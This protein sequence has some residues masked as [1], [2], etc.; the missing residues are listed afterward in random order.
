MVTRSPK[1][2]L[3]RLIHRV[4]N[5][6]ALSSSRGTVSAFK[7][8]NLVLVPIKN[9][10][11]SRG[12]SSIRRYTTAA[13]PRSDASQNPYIRQADPGAVLQNRGTRTDEC[14]GNSETNCAQSVRISSGSGPSHVHVDCQ[15]RYMIFLARKIVGAKSPNGSKNL[16]VNDRIPRFVKVIIA[17][18]LSS[19]QK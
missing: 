16:A 18:R 10:E 5:N 3:I 7:G 11:D 12:A 17:S 8:A 4:N 14:C 15:V 6:A 13:Y 1:T 9:T 19:Q 2:N